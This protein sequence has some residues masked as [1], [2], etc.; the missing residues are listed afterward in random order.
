M[1]IEPLGKGVG[2]YVSDTHHFTTDTILLANF[3]AAKNGERIVEL[4]TGCRV[5]IIIGL[6]GCLPVFVP[7]FRAFR[8]FH[9]DRA[10][11]HPN[12]AFLKFRPADGAAEFFRSVIIFSVIYSRARI[13]KFSVQALI[14]Q[15]FVRI[16]DKSRVHRFH[17]I[18]S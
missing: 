4:G 13:I 15:V 9:K 11:Y 18:I 5:K 7:F 3:A 1:R 16:D 10:E 14:S 12:P 8:W 17:Y 6:I 2:I